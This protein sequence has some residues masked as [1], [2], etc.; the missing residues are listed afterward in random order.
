VTEALRQAHEEH[1]EVGRQL[2]ETDEK[3]EEDSYICPLCNVDIPKTSG[4]SHAAACA[5]LSQQREAE[6]KGEEEMYFCELCF[7]DMKI[8]EMEDHI[9]AHSLEDDEVPRRQTSSRSVHRHRPGCV[10]HS[11]SPVEADMQDDNTVQPMHNS[12]RVHRHR[13]VP[14]PHYFQHQR[15]PYLADEPLSLHPPLPPPFSMPRD[16]SVHPHDPFLMQ[17]P[18]PLP[19]FMP[20]R[21]ELVRM[22]AERSRSMREQI[23]IPGSELTRLFRHLHRHAEDPSPAQPDR[24]LD[25]RHYHGNA[26]NESGLAA[27]NKMKYNEAHSHETTQCPVC[28]TDYA[29]GDSLILLPCFHYLHEECGANW[30]AV[31]AECP[32]CKHKV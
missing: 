3:V 6:Q 18:F 15:V 24:Y 7:L 4:M 17:D 32:T 29:N 13:Y 12:G 10:H 14:P 27:L 25:K 19:D 23:R 21:E 2:R 22:Q 8:S 30:L 16:D 28:M 9:F 11:S 5:G 26:L 20:S 1:C 31:K